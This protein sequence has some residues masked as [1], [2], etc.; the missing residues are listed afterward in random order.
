VKDLLQSLARPRLTGSQG[1][2]EVADIVHEHLAK[3]GYDIQDHPFTFST[4]PG[5]FAVSLAGLLFLIGVITAAILMQMQ[6]PGVA[7]VVL[8]VVLLL[9]GAIAALA[10]PL[11]T[12]LPFGRITGNNMLAAK[13]GATPRYIFM[14]HLDSKSQPVPLAF[15][16]PA[17]ILAILTWLAFVIYA[18]LALLDAV[19]MRGD[20]TSVLAVLAGA[21]GLILIFCWTGNKSPGALDNGSG[22]ATVLAL[23]ESERDR[24]DVAFLITDA[25]ELGLVGARAIAGKLNPVFGVINID[26]VDDDGPLYVLEKFGVPPRHI[27][28]HL[29]ASILQAADAMDLP[30]QRRNVPFGLLLDH[31]PMARAHLPAVT[32]MRGSFASLRRVHRPADDVSRM[33]GAGIQTVTKLLRDALNLLRQEAAMLVGNRA[34]R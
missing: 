4:W 14:A 15:R 10:S 11:T 5:R 25:E 19:W 22:L 27:A 1:A 17:I 8:L 23:A 16:G 2:Q 34:A 7:L 20:I 24:D 3:L 21:A 26:G 30:A 13:P 28:P 29:V 18:L 9:G 6:H 33:S 31:L 12:I 32:V